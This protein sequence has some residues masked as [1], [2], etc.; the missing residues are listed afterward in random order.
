M[1]IIVVIGLIDVE[2]PIQPGESCGFGLFTELPVAGSLKKFELSL[3]IPIGSNY[4]QQSI[5]IKIIYNRAAAQT[6]C[7]IPS[8]VAT[9]VKRGIFHLNRTP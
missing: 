4:V 6:V 5:P 2:S 9:S 1:T 8:S 3:H 7:L